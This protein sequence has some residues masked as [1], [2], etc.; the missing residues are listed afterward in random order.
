MIYWLDDKHF[1]IDSFFEKNIDEN[2]TF[3]MFISPKGFDR[4]GPAWSTY[5]SKKYVKIFNPRLNLK[6]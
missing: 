2:M 1:E 4:I 3:K 6:K 5:L